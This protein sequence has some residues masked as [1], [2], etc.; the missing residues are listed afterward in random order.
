MER[1]RPNAAHSRRESKQVKTPKF[2]THRGARENLPNVVCSDPLPV[3][4]PAVAAHWLAAARRFAL[5]RPGHVSAAVS[6]THARCLRAENEAG[7]LS[8]I[9]LSTSRRAASG[10]RRSAEVNRQVSTQAHSCKAVLSCLA[11]YK[12]YL[13]SHSSLL[14]TLIAHVIKSLAA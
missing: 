8:W 2:C 4:V 13:D 9:V 1:L 14:L 3:A 10:R 11:P 7:K 5:R 6:S 12:S